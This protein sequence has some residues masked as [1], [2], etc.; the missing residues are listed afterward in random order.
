MRSFIS[1]VF[2]VEL[3][4]YVNFTLSVTEISVLYPECTETRGDWVAVPSGP[5]V[6]INTF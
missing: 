6:F 3:L 1:S 4:R 5:V 2:K